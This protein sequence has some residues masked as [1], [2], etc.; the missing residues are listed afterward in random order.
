VSLVEFYGWDLKKKKKLNLDVKKFLQGH[1]FTEQHSFKGL[2]EV[3]YVAI[4]HLN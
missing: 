2:F 4:V 1:I 3:A